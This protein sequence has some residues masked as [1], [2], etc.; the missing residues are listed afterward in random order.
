M[1]AAL[2]PQEIYL[3]ER[4]SSLGYFGQLR[5]SFAACVAAS[6]QALFDFI[7]N[8]P[9]DYR[10][11]ALS[12]QPDVVWGERVLPNMRWVLD[13]LNQAY[14]R[15]SQGDLDGLA[16]AGN[17]KTTFASINRDYS[18]EWMP[19]A[20]KDE[21]DRQESISSTLASNINFTALG[22]WT[23]G[24]LTTRYQDE[25]RGV[26][27]AP[28]SWPQYRPNPDVRV[29]TDEEVPCNGIYL[30]D[31]DD[32]CAE[33]LIKGYEAWP[34]LRPRDSAQPLATKRSERS[35]VSTWTLIERVADIGGGVPGSND[36]ITAGVRL[37]CESGRPCPLE[38]WWFSPA[39]TGGPQ[40]FYQGELMPDMGSDYGLTIWQLH[41]PQT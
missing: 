34:V 6:E 16:A 13:G 14:T 10:N 36:P 7:R 8:L 27:A 38:G 5:D 15:I 17:V 26:L 33:L 37:R 23:K 30:P 28:A 19:Q 2:N 20:C 41:S 25:A 32:G 40:R 4:Y 24:S 3:L 21:T 35:I 39:A 12:D 18:W 31:S 9:P 29:R 22:E 11:R 1:A